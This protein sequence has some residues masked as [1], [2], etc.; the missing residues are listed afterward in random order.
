MITITEAATAQIKTMMEQN[1]EANYMRVG[2]QGGGCTGLSY[3]MGFESDVHDD[4]QTLE[5]NEIKLV[6]DNE[7]APMLDGVTIDYKTNMMGGGFTLDNP[8]AIANC[9]CGASFRTATN[10]G[11]PE[12]C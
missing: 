3:G 10:A 1:D 9:G 7:S 6:V 12:N 2:V 8:N 11:T 4:D 5:V